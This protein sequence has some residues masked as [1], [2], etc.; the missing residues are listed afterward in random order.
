MKT[1]KNFTSSEKNFFHIKSAIQFNQTL[2]NDMFRYILTKSMDHELL[3]NVYNSLETY[4]DSLDS[5]I[6]T[7]LSN[8]E[9]NNQKNSN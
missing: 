4:I 7:N 1:Y 6:S 2:L 3:N 8:H 9:N 5:L